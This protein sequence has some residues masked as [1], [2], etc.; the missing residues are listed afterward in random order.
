MDDKTKLI[1]RMGSAGE[2]K[3]NSAAV[4]AAKSKSRI[5]TTFGNY[6]KSSFSIEEIST[7]SNNATYPWF[8]PAARIR[9]ALPKELIEIPAMPKL[10][11]PPKLNWVS[12]L[13]AP[14]CMVFIMLI[15]AVIVGTNTMIYMLPM[16]LISVIVSVVNYFTQKKAHKA[17]QAEIDTKY[18]TLLDAKRQDLQNRTDSV[19]AI[20]EEENPSPHTCLKMTKNKEHLWERTR[21]DNDF[22]TVRIGVGS[23]D[24]GEFV[25]APK[26]DDFQENNELEEEART[27]VE[28]FHYVHDCPILCDLLTKQ[29]TGI[30]G[31]RETA[32]NI[33]RQMIMG[34]AGLHCYD[35]VKLVM[36]YPEAEA[37]IWDSFRFLPHVFDNQHQE[38]YMTCDRLEA[39]QLLEK[40]KKL[41]AER[42]AAKG[43]LFAKTTVALPH[44]VIF[45][46]D[47][48]F[49]QNDEIADLLCSNSEAI[50]AST[51]FVY[52]NRSQI[53]SRCLQIVNAKENNQNEIYNTD[54][55]ASMQMFRSECI[56]NE[57]IDQFSRSLAP[58][59]LMQT[60]GVK[61]LPTNVTLLEAHGVNNPDSLHILERWRKNAAYKSMRV[62]IGVCAD[63]SLFEFDIHEK[64]CGP[65]GLIAGTTR[66]GKTDL[67]RTWVTEMALTFS[68]DDVAFVLIDF[69]G[70]SLTAPFVG[71][72]HLA[73]A[74]S[75]L[76]VDPDRDD[77]IL[78]YATSLKS[79]ISRR[80]HVL[81]DAGCDGNILLYHKKKQEG[82]VKKPLPF[83]MIVLDEFAEIK[84]QYPE[85]M[86]LVE[87]L[88]ATGGSL[89]MYVLLATQHPSSAINDKIRANT[90]FRWC[91]RVESDADSKEMI[92]IA[93]A[94][95]LSEIPGRGFIRVDKMRI[96]K[97]IQG[98]WC[99]AP[100]S[101][102]QMVKTSNAPV[103]I[104]RRNGMLITRKTDVSRRG[105][106]ETETK[107]IVRKMAT[108]AKENGY[109][110][111]HRVWERN[112]PRVLLLNEIENT[113]DK[114]SWVKVDKKK[115]EMTVGLADVP[116]M[117][118]QEPLK[119]EFSENGSGIIYGA[120]QTGKTTFLF[121]LLTSMTKEYSP[122]EAAC[123]LIDY[124]TG[125]LAAF[126]D[127]PH[128]IDLCTLFDEKQ[129]LLKVLDSI[130]KEVSTRRKLFSSHAIGDYQAYLTSDLRKQIEHPFIL[131]AVDG[132][133]ELR[134]TY[135]EVIDPFIDNLVR[136]GSHYGIYCFL[137]ASEE[138]DTYRVSG[139]IKPAMRFVLQ[140]ASKNE[141]SS[142]LGARGTTPASFQGRGICRWD[143][144]IVE[145][146]T[147]LPI[148]REHDTAHMIDVIKE[149][150][151]RM[152]TRFEVS[153][154]KARTQ[155][156]PSIPY[157][158]IK[159]NTC[160][161]ILG[162]S[163][164]D[165]TP[166]IHNFAVLPALLAV[167]DKP[168]DCTKYIDL[169]TKQL[170]EKQKIDTFISYDTN[171]KTFE[172]EEYSIRREFE[173]RLVQLKEEL[174]GRLSE[175]KE[176]RSVVFSSIVISIID[177]PCFLEET[178]EEYREMLG[179]M[180]RIGR[181]TSTYL[182]ASGKTEDVVT[183]YE[184]EEETIRRY[185]NRGIIID[186]AKWNEYPLF[187]QYATDTVQDVRLPLYL[188]YEP[189]KGLIQAV[190]FKSME[191][192]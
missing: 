49:L 122:A 31:H 47:P 99:G 141:Y 18:R 107:A 138:R 68:P 125:S 35:E 131:V 166:V 53:P 152:K 116:S 161:P 72:P 180:I 136:N 191:C 101:P 188:H 58:V 156:P 43:A 76:D 74:I 80:Q 175:W 160:Q 69:K 17:S 25:R 119:V 13:A 39:A 176:D 192:K 77:F 90:A 103:A 52:H 126:A 109:A 130:E 60:N 189:G 163:V 159:D 73:G 186:G 133:S 93:D 33:C 144:M 174:R 27:I 94:A 85:F 64:Q 2:N 154:R 5:I 105:D 149:N 187:S 143:S 98:L 42:L 19:R 61:G 12:I 56:S 22:L 114:N 16:Q 178:S 151:K 170:K 21:Y 95:H 181:N 44:F 164:N 190:Q 142:I 59:R 157:G 70:S 9:H 121:T 155:L 7:V 41:F 3:K 15:M 153:A 24:Y 117:Q 48:V 102:F 145:F 67:L 132:Y 97:E 88:Y 32:I 84:S 26:K 34:I 165:A 137:T 146:Q 185:F 129:A 55:T 110:S 23:I 75:N 150:G 106:E 113:F 46:A 87:S 20:L 57:E 65:M 184:K 83:L 96:N 36:L 38:R 148:E 123:Y 104:V 100:Y 62:P 134:K 8:S 71:M 11:A 91:L 78:R 63:G 179:A 177:L 45:I 108:I 112:L 139:T 92:G 183:L 54:D 82:K 86:K 169:V 124:N 167:S 4:K 40:L 168:T 120:P 6:P 182:I 111:T 135:S 115:L 51:V 127:Y 172:H 171:K 50:G 128:T 37:E 140:M 158:S 147:A 14:I 89:G 30:I 1:S 81:R 118:K 79:E 28:E 29:T 173:E 162:L 66:S 10:G